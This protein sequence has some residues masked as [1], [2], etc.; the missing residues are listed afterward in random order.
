MND[1]DDN[2]WMNDEL[3]TDDIQ[4]RIYPVPLTIFL[5]LNLKASLHVARIPS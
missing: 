5:F 1:F 4:Q 3:M 2:N